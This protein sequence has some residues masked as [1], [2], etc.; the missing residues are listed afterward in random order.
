MLYKVVLRPSYEIK[1]GINYDFKKSDFGSYTKI[2]VKLIE[3]ISL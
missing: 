1:V 2:W 3:N